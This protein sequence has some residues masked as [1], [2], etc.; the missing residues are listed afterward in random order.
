M[1]NP[2]DPN[3]L[4]PGEDSVNDTVRTEFQS[5]YEAVGAS[6]TDQALGSTGAPGDILTGCIVQV[7]IAATSAVSIKD[8]SGSAIP[9]VP[10]NTPIGV[11]PIALFGIVALDQGWKATTA[12]GATVLFAGRFT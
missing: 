1:W 12:A 3:V 8:G 5:D 7:T 2:L 6:A 9:L 10:A 4:K 11:Y